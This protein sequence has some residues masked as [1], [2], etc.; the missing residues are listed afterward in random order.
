MGCPV[1]PNL[2][3]LPSESPQYSAGACAYRLRP[4]RVLS[5]QLR[6][7]DLT[8]RPTALKGERMGRRNGPKMGSGPPHLPPELRRSKGLRMT[9]R[10]EE[11]SDLQTISAAWNVPTS[12]VAW[13]IVHTELQKCR[14]RAPNLGD[15]GLAIAVAMRVLGRHA[16]SAESDAP[17]ATSL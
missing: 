6:V 2:L 15:A 16:E 9:L 8:D 13:A 1:A 17:R 14:K 10:D 12:T 4:P 5:A 11:F 3:E 7:M